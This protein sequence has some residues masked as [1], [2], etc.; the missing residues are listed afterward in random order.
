MLV[1]LM[2][3][4]PFHQHFFLQRTATKACVRM[5]KGEVLGDIGFKLSVSMA[6]IHVPRMW[7]EELADDPDDCVSFDYWKCL[8]ESPEV[9]R[10]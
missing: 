10:N 1:S 9:I 8:I 5:A 3:T 6:E 2:L 4:Y 7:V